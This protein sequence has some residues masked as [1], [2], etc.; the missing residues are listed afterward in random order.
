MRGCPPCDSTKWLLLRSHVWDE[1][2]CVCACIVIGFQSCATC[3][4]YSCS[5]VPAERSWCRWKYDVILF[6]SDTTELLSQCGWQNC[7]CLWVWVSFRR[8]DQFQT[9]VDLIFRCSRCEKS[10]K[11]LLCK[12]LYEKAIYSSEP[13][14]PTSVFERQAAFK[15]WQFFRAKQK[16]S[17]DFQ[18]S[19]SLW[20]YHVWMC[21]KSKFKIKITLFTMSYLKIC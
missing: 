16:E 1:G 19:D 18:L 17:S 13:R 5:S 15:K 3:Y 7:M 6:T 14:E 10:P 8:K 21:H 2:V 4:L 12:T 11:D 20:M 9:F